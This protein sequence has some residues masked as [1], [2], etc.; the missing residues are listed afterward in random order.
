VFFTHG[1]T[2]L[3]SWIQEGSNLQNEVL[4]WYSSRQYFT[5]NHELAF[6]AVLIR[7]ILASNVYQSRWYNSKL[8]H[9]VCFVDQL[10]VM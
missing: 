6:C 9:I 10:H 4:I 8:D 1:E 7:P 2:I 3:L 5:S